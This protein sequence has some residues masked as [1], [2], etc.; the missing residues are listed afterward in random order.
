MAFFSIKSIEN[1]SFIKSL[2]KYYHKRYLQKWHKDIN[3]F[4]VILNFLVKLITLN[5]EILDLLKGFEELSNICIKMDYL[6]Y[7]SYLQN[8]NHIKFTLVAAKMFTYSL[9]HN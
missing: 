8:D 4:S 5:Q 6:K 9:S 1:F 3:L 2:L 7:N